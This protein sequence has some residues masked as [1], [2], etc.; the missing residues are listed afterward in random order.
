MRAIAAFILGAL[1]VAVIVLTIHD[2][3]NISGLKRQHIRLK[4]LEAMSK[5]T[6]RL[7]LRYS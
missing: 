7:G 4:A 5:K 3:Q 1:S 6:E 2:Q